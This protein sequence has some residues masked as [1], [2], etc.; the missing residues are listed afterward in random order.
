MDAVPATGAD[1]GGD[2]RVEPGGLEVRGPVG[3]AAGQVTESRVGVE[4]VGCHFH[5]QAP[6]AQD[7]AAVVEADGVDRAAGGD[8][9][10]PVP[11]D[12][13]G[14]TGQSTAHSSPGFVLPQLLGYVLRYVL[15]RVLSHRQVLPG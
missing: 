4:D 11:G 9:G 15:G 14:R 3:V 5:L 6:G 12:E 2:R 8:D 7:R 10:D 13:V 1:D